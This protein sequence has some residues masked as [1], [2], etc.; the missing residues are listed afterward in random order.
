M[1]VL[2]ADGLN[3]AVPVDSVAK[4]IAHF[5]RNG[6]VVQLKNVSLCACQNSL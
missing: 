6:Y 1:K 2:G 5:N 3:F 4:I